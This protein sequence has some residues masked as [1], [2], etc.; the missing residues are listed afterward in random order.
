VADE[1]TTAEVAEYL[2]LG[3]AAAA[4]A[5]LARWGIRPVARQPGRAGQNLYNPEDVHGADTARFGRGR[6][7]DLMREDP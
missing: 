6:R 3:S 1:W 2:R 4:R 7:T 5:Q